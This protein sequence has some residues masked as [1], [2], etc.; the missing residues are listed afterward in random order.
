MPYTSLLREGR[1][2]YHRVDP[3]ELG[4][5]L[6]LARARLSDAEVDGV[7][8][9][10]RYICAYEAAHAAARAVMHAEGYRTTSG[11]GHH[12]GAFEFLALV[13]NGRWA[14][15]A[16]YLDDCRKL[17][18]TALYGHVGVASEHDR[19]SLVRAARDLVADVRDWL[20]E[21]GLLAPDEPADD[22][23]PPDP[24]DSL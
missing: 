8:D 14:S 17:R 15:E 24:T 1:I 2:R 10:M 12:A 20:A 18:N 5:E 4:E 6:A 22:T 23:A 16:E 13:D 7:S 11:P 3:Q 9:D 19:D 21:R